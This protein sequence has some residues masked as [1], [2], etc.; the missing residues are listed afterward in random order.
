VDYLPFESVDQRLEK[1]GI[2][3]ECGTTLTKLI[4]PDGGVLFA[5]PFG[6]AP[7]KVKPQ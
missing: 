6:S 1:H 2:K 5:K 4:G 3:V 7:S